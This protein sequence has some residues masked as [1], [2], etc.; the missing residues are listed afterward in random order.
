MKRR[1][2]I[3][4]GLLHRPQ[5]VFMDEPTVGI[6]PQSRRNMLGTF[7]TSEGRANGLSIMLGMA[8]VLLGGCWP[9]PCSSSPSASAVS[10]TNR[11]G[12]P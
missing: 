7:I 5:L 3:A 1:I 12:A 8:M 6:D 2:N 11:R 10:A 4:V 9:S